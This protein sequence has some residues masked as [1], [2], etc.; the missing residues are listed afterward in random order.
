ML[1]FYVPPGIGDF[2]AM[3]CKLCHIKRAIVIKPAADMPKRL[4]PFLDILPHIK[5]GG[6]GPHSTG[7][8][9]SLTLSPGTEL[10]SLDDGEYF[11]SIN[12]WL[13]SGRNVESW[14]PGRTDYHYDTLAPEKYIN[15]AKR[16][17]EP[18]TSV[19]KVGIY[20]SAYGNSRHWG[21]WGPVEWRQFLVLIMGVLPPE[22]QYIF[23]G[24]D[25]DVMI[26]EYLY[27]W[28]VAENLNGH[29]TMGMFHIAS[30]MEL[31]RNL[32]YFFV[33]PSGLGFLADVVRTPH[34]M[35]FPGELEK[36][37]GTFCDPA[38]YQSGQSLHKQFA[39]PEQAFEDFKLVGL[40]FFEERARRYG[41]DN[42]K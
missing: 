13:E 14:I 3:Y 4:E 25:Y 8:C 2:S 38:Q 28:M 27:Q 23:I 26:S 41:Q 21:F 39:P 30:T 5:N 10:S 37:K 11:L 22:T 31:I 9:L 35:W 40:K 36:M 34:L 15:S 33:F 19:P 24:A 17:L 29:D 16:F 1:T 32:D 20:C 7:A 18:I 12:H 42:H 6:Y